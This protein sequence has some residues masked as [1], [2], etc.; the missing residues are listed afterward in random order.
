MV[1][2]CA[3]RKAADDDDEDRRDEGRRVMKRERRTWREYRANTNGGEAADGV[4][5]WVGARSTGRGRESSGE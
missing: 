5:K 1:D 2:G 3:L 4:R